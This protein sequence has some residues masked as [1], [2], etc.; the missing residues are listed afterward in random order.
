MMVVWV[1]EL[2]PVAAGWDFESVHATEAGAKAAA[3]KWLVDKREQWRN[4]EGDYTFANLD[5]DKQWAWDWA[6]EGDVESWSEGGY[7]FQAR[8]TREPLGP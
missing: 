5:D 1:L 7:W 2:Y 4:A 6:E 3:D 8:V